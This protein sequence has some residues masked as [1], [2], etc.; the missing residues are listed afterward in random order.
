[1]ILTFLGKLRIKIQLLRKISPLPLSVMSIHQAEL[2]KMG[3]KIA[4]KKI[5]FS[6]RDQNK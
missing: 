1:M 3:R 4:N 6:N 5:E 2:F